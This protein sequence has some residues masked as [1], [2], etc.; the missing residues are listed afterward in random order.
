MASGLVA[1]TLSWI[2]MSSDTFH[3]MY[4]RGFK[5]KA[6]LNS[7]RKPQEGR[8][9]LLRDRG[10]HARRAIGLR[11]WPWKFSGSFS[12]ALV[13]KDLTTNRGFLNWGIPQNHGFPYGLIFHDLEVPTLGNLQTASGSFPNNT[14]G[15]SLHGMKPSTETRE[16]RHVTSPHLSP[17]PHRIVDTVGCQTWLRQQMCT[18]R[19]RSKS[20]V[21]QHF[22]HHHAACFKSVTGVVCNFWIGTDRRCL[23]YSM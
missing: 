3:R 20:Y 19:A 6:L 7:F 11:A 8:L 21:F 16:P 23:N 14:A 2:N 12:P 4:T 13:A 22:T 17:E 5:C 9:C 1:K 10:I 15:V 18:R